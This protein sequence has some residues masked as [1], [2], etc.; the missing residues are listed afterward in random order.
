MLLALSSY[1]W[2]DFSDATVGLLF[3]IAGVLFGYALRGLIGRFQ[4]QAIEK[5]AEG[6]L[7]D[8]DVEVKNRLK[9]ADIQARATVVKAREE[10]EKSTKEQK[11]QLAEEK[12]RLERRDLGLQEKSDQLD[13]RAVALAEK[14]EELDLGA[15]ALRRDRIELDR[16]RDEAEARLTALAGMTG[17]EARRERF[18]EAECELQKEQGLLIRKCQEAVRENCDREAQ[19]IVVSAIQ[20]YSISHAHEAMSYTFTLEND[21]VKGR[22]V[23]REGRNIRALECATGVSFLIDENPGVVILSSFDPVRREIARRALEKLIADGRIHPSRIEEVVAEVEQEV[24]KGFAEAGEKAAFQAQLMNVPKPISELLGRL[25]FRTSFSQNVLAH[26][27]EVANLMG[28]MAGDL[29]LDPAL[30]RRVGLF[31]DIGKALDHEKQGK[32]AQLGADFLQQN[33]E[34][35]IVVNA[36]AAHHEDVPAESVYAVLCSAADAISSSRPGARVESTEIYVERVRKLEELAVSRPG[37]VKA[38]ALQAGRE[39]RVIVDPGEIDDNA[40]A[41]MA[42]ELGIQIET[43]MRYPGQIRVIVIREKRCIEVAR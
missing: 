2:Y 43:T 13:R 20:R 42:R 24:A 15:E 27:V 22:I 32:H 35:E 14:R 4:A 10:F 41:V 28:M 5:Q 23:G 34:H 36:V 26:S 17:E 39:L 37:V 38:Y 11:E 16:A 40:A 31:H 12:A 21:A 8:A 25:S 30:A 3:G 18:A 9:E 6:K 19:A 33:G 29:G 1:S 7:I